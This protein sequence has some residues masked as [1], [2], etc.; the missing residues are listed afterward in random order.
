MALGASVLAY[1]A[2]TQKNPRTM[3]NFLTRFI[4]DKREFPTRQYNYF[5]KKKKRPQGPL[6]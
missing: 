1:S 6:S 5:K 2:K 3:A 4:G